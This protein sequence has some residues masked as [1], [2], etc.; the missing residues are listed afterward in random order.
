MLTDKWTRRQAAATAPYE[1]VTPQGCC[2]AF[3][4]NT[5]F[6]LQTATQA[7]KPSFCFLLYTLDKNPPYPAQTAEKHSKRKPGRRKERSEEH[8]V[9]VTLHLL[10]PYSSKFGHDEYATRWAAPETIMPPPSEENLPSPERFLVGNL[11]LSVSPVL[12][13]DK[14]IMETI[15]KII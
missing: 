10:M 14:S 4:H 1:P 6:S 5:L 12:Y 11:F 2:F 7:C 3:F 13:D 9:S 8:M 15:G